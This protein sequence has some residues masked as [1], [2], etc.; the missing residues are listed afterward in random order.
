MAFSRASSL[1]FFNTL[2]CPTMQFSSTVMLL[3]RLK[4][5]NTMPILDRYR[6]AFTPSA[7]HV[8]AVEKDLAAGG[9]LQQVDAPQQGGLA[10]PGGADDAGHVP[11]PDGEV[12]VLQDLVAA[13][14]LAEVPHFQDRVVHYRP[15]LFRPCFNS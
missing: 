12:N 3:N 8:L 2:T 4:D 7:G 14:G 13:E 11:G 5:W 10:G 6:E 15:P 1:D 9:R